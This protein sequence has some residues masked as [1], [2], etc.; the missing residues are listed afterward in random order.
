MQRPRALISL[1]NGSLEGSGRAPP[2]P[3]RLVSAFIATA[4]AKDDAVA[5]L[6]QWRKADQLRPKLP[7][8]AVC[9]DEV[10]GGR[11]LGYDVPARLPRKLGL[12]R[13]TSRSHRQHQ[14]ATNRDLGRTDC[15]A[16]AHPCLSATSRFRILGSVSNSETSL[17]KAV[18]SSGAVT[19][20]MNF[21]GVP[22]MW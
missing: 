7:K 19:V 9:L 20:P 17:F 22:S 14:P 8:L 10:E 16:L 2:L 21:A 6:A 12:L 3:K 5:Y 18:C 15:A 4:F 13:W 11:R 1:F